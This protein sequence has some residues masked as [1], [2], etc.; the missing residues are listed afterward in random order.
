MKA[1]AEVVWMVSQFRNFGNKVWKMTGRKQG[2]RE[3]ERR[4]LIDRDTGIDKQRKIEY[5]FIDVA[6]YLCKYL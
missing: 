3:G 2:E 4:G 5:T 1:E 6:S